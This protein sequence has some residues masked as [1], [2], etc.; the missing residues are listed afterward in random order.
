MKAAD[1]A[2]TAVDSVATEAPVSDQVGEVI[3]DQAWVCE[4]P[5]YEPQPY[6][7]VD[8]K[9][10]VDPAIIDDSCLIVDDSTLIP[11]DRPIDIRMKFVASETDP[12]WAAYFYHVGPN[13]VVQGVC[14][15]ASYDEPT[16]AAFVVAHADDPGVRISDFGDGWWIEGFPPE[17]APAAP[18]Q[19]IYFA[20]GDVTTDDNAAYFMPADTGMIGDEGQSDIAIAEPVAVDPR[21]AAFADMGMMAAATMATSDTSTD[22]VIIGGGRRRR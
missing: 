22:G 6:A 1:A 11:V 9:P 16:I 13:G 20:G 17:L 14:V 10:I 4:L 15:M 2:D 19:S 12:G 21:S 3:T 18:E 5:A 8:P 7:P